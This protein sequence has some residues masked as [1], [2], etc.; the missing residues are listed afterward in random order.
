[1]HS[2]IPDAF[3]YKLN[4]SSELLNMQLA[5][6]TPLGTEILTNLIYKECDV[7]TGTIKIKADLI[8][9][10]KLEYDAILGMD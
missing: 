10:G 1:M 5:I 4:K 2:F 9:L 6:S 3:A 7:E 8:K